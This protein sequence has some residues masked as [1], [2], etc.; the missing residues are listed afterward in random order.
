MATS[1]IEQLKAGSAMKDQVNKQ[2]TLQIYQHE[3][4]VLDYERML[5]MI[6]PKY[7][8][9]HDV[10]ETGQARWLT[11]ECS[12]CARVYGIDI[13]GLRYWQSS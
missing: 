11:L 9:R 2:L 4:K 5:E 7:V 8:P 1:E 12:W 3:N 13:S 10:I 6:K